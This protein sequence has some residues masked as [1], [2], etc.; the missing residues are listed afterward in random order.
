MIGRRGTAAV[1]AAFVLL[2]GACGGDEEPAE[3]TAPAVGG[4]VPGQA[5]GTS[6]TTDAPPDTEADDAPPLSEVGAALRPVGGTEQPV[7]LT[8]RP[9]SDL[10]YVVENSGRIVAMEEGDEVVEVAVALDLTGVALTDGGEQGV[11]GLAFSVDGATMYVHHT[12]LDGE[13]RIA[14]YTMDGDV[15]DAGSRVDILTVDQP[16]ANH[17]G[18]EIVLGPDGMLWIGLGDGGA[19][20]DPDDRAQDPDDLLGK[21]LRIDPT[22][23]SDGR[24]YGIP[25]DNPYADGGGRPEIAVTGLRNPWRFRFDPATGD[26][27]IADVGQNLWEEIDRVP[28][29][30]VLGANLG[31]SRYEGSHDFD[32]D[33]ELRGDTEPTFPVFELAHDDGWCSVTG[34]EVYRSYEIAGLDGAYVFGDYCQPGLS[35]IRVRDDGSVDSV[36]LDDEITGVT[37]IDATADGRIYVLTIGGVILR[38]EPT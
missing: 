20:D 25:S 33:H 10:L 32:E 34:G 4:E 30:E 35:A 36:V 27:W 24:A 17:N 31:W 2:V 14:G 16:H 23:P 15:A 21:I 38:L 5:P 18:G 9:G 28:A 26:L 12:G 19:Q 29:D 8:S 13:T 1:A 37:S 22:A 11:L 6:S 3:T 7:K